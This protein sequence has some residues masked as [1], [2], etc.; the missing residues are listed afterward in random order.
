LA[1]YV[2]RPVHKNRLNHA[3]DTDILRRAAQVIWPLYEIG[4]GCNRQAHTRKHAH[5]YYI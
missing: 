1:V 4:Y 2:E 3:A 5:T